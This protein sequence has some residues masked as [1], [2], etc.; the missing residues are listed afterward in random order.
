VCP[1][2]YRAESSYWSPFPTIWLHPLLLAYSSV[3]SLQLLTQRHEILLIAIARQILTAQAS[4]RLQRECA[5]ESYTR[6]QMGS[7]NSY[8]LVIFLP[9]NKPADPA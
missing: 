2:R 9:S 1:A 5:T 3:P 4:H 8:P 6:V 7:S